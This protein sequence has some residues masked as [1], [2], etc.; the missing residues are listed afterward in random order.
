MK[1]NGGGLPRSGTRDAMARKMSI[2]AAEGPGA[3]RSAGLTDRLVLSR[4]RASGMFGSADPKGASRLVGPFLACEPDCAEKGVGC[5]E[6]VTHAAS[7]T[8][9]ARTIAWER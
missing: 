6:L 4:S 1:R 7:E 9:G 2:S 3:A 5:R 8:E